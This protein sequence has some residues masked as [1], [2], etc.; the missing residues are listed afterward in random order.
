MPFYEYRCDECAKTFELRRSSE[1]ANAPIACSVGHPARR[2]F[3]VFAT[4]GAASAP[5]VPAPPPMPMGG[6]CGGSCC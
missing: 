3:S 1:D 5:G 6:C 2:V 4:V